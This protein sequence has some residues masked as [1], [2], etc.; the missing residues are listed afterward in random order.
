M[1]SADI[2]GLK[3]LAR[4]VMWSAQSTGRIAATAG[5]AQLGFLAAAIETE[6]E[7]RDEPG[8][9]RYRRQAGFPVVKGFAGY[10]WSHVALPPALARDDIETCRF[11][12]RGENLVL[13]GPVGTGKTHLATA[14]GHA[15]C[16]LGI[17]VKYFTVS[18]LVLRL[19]EA[20]R[21]GALDKT[22][23][24]IGRAQLLV[25]DEFGYVPVDRDAARLL[26][27]VVSDAYETRSLVITTNQAFSH[28]G[29][30]L[31][32]DQMASA[33]TGRIAH[34]GHLVTF[35]GQSWR[36]THAL[37]AANNQKG[38]RP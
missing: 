11:V 22:L 20:Q 36:M 6:L 32:D 9:A 21:A 15:G 26:F 23:S 37:M 8:K 28:W 7:C 33:M 34:H 29:A 24:A 17:A 16:A 18:D 27:K 19:A 3:G 13:L 10:D 12:E 25:L 31:T 1:T 30:V 2:Q 35:A 38:T 4:R 5:D 14:I